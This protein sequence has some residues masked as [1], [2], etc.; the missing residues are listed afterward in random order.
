MSPADATV[1]RFERAMSDAEGLM[2]RMEK[3][4]H[5]SSTFANVTVL[6]RPVDFDRL[7]RRLE[8]AVYAI[9]RL[10]QRVQSTPAN[11]SPPMWVDDPNFDLHHH[12]RHLALPAP[13]SMRQLLDLASLLTADAFDRTRPLWQFIAVDGLEGG[14]GALIEKFHHTLVDG[15]AGVQLSMQ[16]LDLERTPDEPPPLD[17]DLIAAAREAQHDG[18]PFDMLRDMIAGSFRMPIGVMR[19]VRDLLGDPGQIPDAGAAAADALRTVV[20][21]LAESDASRSPLWTTRSLR[22]RM[23]VLRAPFGAT[24]DAA[25]RLG[26]TLNTA[27]LSCTADADGRYHRELGAPVPELRASMAIST[28]NDDSG[29][30]AFSLA[31]MLVPTAEMTVEERFS[32]IQR[33]AEGARSTGTAASLDSLAAFAGTLPTS[34]ITRIARQQ[35]H[36]VDFATSNVR[37]AP[38]PLYVA[39]ARLEANYPLGPLG[40]VAFNLTLLSYDHSLD[41]GVNI[42]A[43]AVTEP[44]LLRTCLEGAFE[45]LTSVAA[46]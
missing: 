4:P 42:D 20:Q 8:R 3:D 44:E 24:R 12:V 2:W 22:R 7:L 18:A 9:P 33:I 29:A 5:L 39:G 32:A 41:M 14:R 45:D 11:I 37:G 17:P 31:K 10:H 13:G 23:E 36:T 30:N 27:F 15:E 43:A 25:R 26:G 28:R 35:A 6:D 1:P 19:Q 34:V 40:G 16:F 46:D 38:I 21:Q